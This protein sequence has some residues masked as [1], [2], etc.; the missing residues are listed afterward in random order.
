M[1]N[2]MMPATLA[3]VLVACEGGRELETTANARAAT[4]FNDGISELLDYCRTCHIPDGVADSPDGERFMLSSD[5]GRDSELFRHSWEVLG[6]GAESSLILRENSESSLGHSGGQSWPVDSAEYGAV[7]AQLKCWDDPQSCDG[8]GDQGAVQSYPLLGSNRARFIWEEFCQDQAD[9]AL[10]PAD[11]RAEIVP[12]TNE[13]RA[14]FFNAWYEDCHV[15]LPEKEQGPQ[16][17]GEYRSSRDRGE[18]YLLGQLIQ[19]STTAAEFDSAWQAWGM[20]AR[21]DNYA[22]LFT[23]RYGNNAAPYNNPYPINGEDPNETNG[24]SG[25]L[26]LGYSQSK[27]AEGNWTGMVG[28]IAC[29]GCHGGQLG[30]ATSGEEI[31]VGYVNLGL[32]NN[33]VDTIQR[34]QDSNATGL[35]VPIPDPLN[36]GV[37]Q[38]GTNNAVGGFEVLFAL[39]DYDSLALN[40]N[41]NKAVLQQGHD[42]SHPTAVVQDTPAWWNYSARAR[43]FFDAG[44]SVDAQRIVLAAGSALANDLA[45]GKTYRDHI[46][47]FDQ[48]VAF[49]IASREA[50]AYPGEIDTQLAEQGAI[51]FHV[52]DL[53][54]EDANA[55]KPRPIGGNGSCASCHGAYSPRFVHNPDFLQ[56]PRFAGMAAHIAPLEVIGTDTARS[57]TL[58]PY[59]RDAYSTTFWGYPD[60]VDG[61]VAPED[62]DLVTEFLD[63]VSTARPEGVCTWERGVIGYQAPPLHGTWATAP[64]FHNGSVPTIEAVLDSSQRPMIWQRQLQ[65]VDGITGFDQRLNEAYDWNQLG[66]KFTELQCDQMPGQ[67]ELNCNPIDDQGPSL[68]QLVEEALYTGLNW[69]ALAPSLDPAAVDKR[70][71]YDTRTLGNGN[72]GHDFSDALSREERRA[73]IEYLKTL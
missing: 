2:L 40:G 34:S 73:I 26:P 68:L 71:I 53:W 36:L 5:A 21:P 37:K 44:V 17:C 23:L 30:D 69:T 55:N 65:T 64:Y 1:K 14:V 48:D 52:K 70:L 56:D 39:L 41:L 38:R 3:V 12:G 29:F 13:G 62:K 50:P 58:T 11:P 67:A 66:W 22:Q 6:G 49:F 33:N 20:D 51:L 31:H 43:K 45:F 46:E 42:F 28:T 24:G 15:N 19:G 63:E 10:L 47:E 27:D 60:H 8:A 7:L 59:L 54:A 25:Q 18:A 16:T 32:G 57:D 4:G 9:D 61:W 72:E 35:P